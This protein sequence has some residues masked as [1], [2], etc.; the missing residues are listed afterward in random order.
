MALD[1]KPFNYFSDLATV[2]PCD[3]FQARLGNGDTKDFC[4]RD[5]YIA[6]SPT[7]SSRGDSVR[8]R[9][10]GDSGLNAYLVQIAYFG[11]PEIFKRLTG[12]LRSFFLLRLTKVA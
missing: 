6:L 8:Q 4:Q 7:P 3:E 2:T 1:Q 5:R 9:I 12:I 11:G 10:L